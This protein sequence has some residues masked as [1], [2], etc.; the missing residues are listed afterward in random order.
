[1]TRASPAD[2]KKELKQ[3]INPRMPVLQKYEA[4]KNNRAFFTQAGSNAE[5]QN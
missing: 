1:M 4:I 2:I 5:F 3:K